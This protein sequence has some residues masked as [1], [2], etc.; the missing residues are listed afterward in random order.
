M[1]V[2]WKFAADVIRLGGVDAHKIAAD[3]GA[4]QQ[5]TARSI[6]SDLAQQPGVI[7]ADEV[8]MGKTYVAL[9]VIASVVRATRGSGR[10]VVV[11]VPS[12]LA[13]KWPREWDQFKA[14]CCAQ[15]DAL[16]WVK[17]KYVHTPTDFF[18]AVGN[19]PGRRP[20]IIWM[21][22]GCFGRG[23]S[24]PW[25]KLALV[26]LARSNTKMDD[27]TKKRIYKWATTLV[28][29]KGERALTPEIVERLMLAHL[30]QWRRLLVREG[31]LRED[32][33]DP[34]PQHLLQHQHEV[35]WSPL[36]AVLRGEAI[37]GR[38]GVVSRRRLNEARS[39]LNE[40]CQQVYWDW[41]SCARWRASLLVLDEAHH[42]KNDPTRLASLFRTDEARRLVTGEQPLLAEKFDRMLFLTAT[43]FQLGHHELIRVLR[44]FAAAKWNGPAAPAGTREEFLGALDEL[45]KRMNENRLAGRRLDRLWGRLAGQAVEGHSDQA[46]SLEAATTWWKRVRDGSS[47]PVDR[48][49]LA[50]IDDCRGTKAR[51]ESDAAR[52]WCSLRPWVIRHNRPTELA[53]AA[54]TKIPRREYRPGRSI[55]EAE[56]AIRHDHAPGAF[57]GLAIA[58]EGALPFLLAARAQGELAQ[59]SAK[60]RAFFAEGLCSSYEAFHH[61]RDNRG[62]ARDV[63]DEGVERVKAAAAASSRGVALI[64]VTWYEEQ[65]Q[66]VIPSKAGP[67]EDRYTHPKIRAVVDRV[68]NLWLAGEKVLV[69][70]FYR[71]TAK[72]LRE[73]L[74]REVEHAI[75]RLAGEKL[76][77]D[78]G[79]DAGWLRSWF[80]RVA[81]RLADE[82]SP[83]SQSIVETLRE[84]LELEEFSVLKPRAAELVQLLAAYVRS[85]SF[86]ARYLPLDVAEVRDALSEGSTRAPVVRAGAAA[87]SR[88]LVE[89]TD[90]SAM[91]MRRRVEE[92]LRFAKELAELGAKKEASHGD[93]E[94]IDPLTEYLEAIAVYVS[95]KRAGDDDDQDAAVRAGQ[96]AYRVLATV[97]MVYGDT[98]PQV[99]ERLMLAFNSPLFPE[100][101]IS[102]AVLAE[103]VDLH[104]FCRYVVHHDLCW[105][106]STLEQRTGRL[107]RIGC[108]AEASQR[109]IVVYEPFLGGSA[110]EKMFRVV[111]DRE[112]WFQIVMGQKFE[113]DEASSEELSNR[114]LLP[115]ELAAEL[116]F[117]L[118]RWRKSENRDAAAK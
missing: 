64:P 53:G 96:G 63:D 25:I 113:F 22:T 55:V 104:R 17:D 80:E 46:N 73:H 97:R 66:R 6:L 44:S 69:F 14:L 67:E 68:V 12:G 27:E 36:V 83:F 118:R 61:T 7:L 101:L 50:A 26:R 40:A 15:P 112:R 29:L 75:L 49:L 57:S 117:D 33:G 24:D 81:R 79:R 105:N 94:T 108:K 3:D 9:A 37:P 8:G 52:P 30:S 5:E 77:R 115:P 84:S 47:D 21:T 38:Q 58:G 51:A 54:G 41:L 20:N 89:R 34:V 116:V 65:I 43:P 4:R 114:I 99:R 39:D 109:P 74:G 13:R 102:S 70:C 78:A 106:P 48:E 103:G 32:D 35:D 59:G 100:I 60:G 42:A 62:D 18:K 111:R 45:E 92:F 28:R 107:D 1:P 2:D 71:E 31:I 23:L 56:D 95:P 76:G 87:L 82:D 10:P 110:D 11:M 16:S 19:S 91:S 72:A 90:A 88:A 93:E 85:P 86:I 98:K